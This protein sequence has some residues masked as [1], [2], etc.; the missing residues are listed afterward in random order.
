[1]LKFTDAQ[2]TFSEVPNEIS[3][4]F[5]ISNCPNHCSGCHSPYLQ[6]DVG[7]PL[8][9]N[10]LDFKIYTNLG[11]TCVCFLGGDKFPE[12]INKLAAHIKSKYPSLL[13]AWYSGNDT[14]SSKI[15]LENFNFIKIGRYD[16]F[17]GALSNPNTNQRF[18]AV[19]MTKEVINNKPV[20]SLIDI[21]NKFWKKS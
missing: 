3:L 8:G 14:L 6:K 5:N 1:M 13:T 18:Y 2:I 21:T 11:I 15:D 20:Y 16:K 17:K 7:L 12:E 9:I 4:C 19:E 10:D